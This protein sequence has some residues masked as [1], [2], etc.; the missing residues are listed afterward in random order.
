MVVPMSSCT[1][2]SRRFTT[3]AMKHFNGIYLMTPF[4]FYEMTAEL[5]S[6]VWQK[7][8]CVRAPL[9]RL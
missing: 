7:S 5:T 9:F 6:Y 3:T 4:M 8:S 1:A 2:F